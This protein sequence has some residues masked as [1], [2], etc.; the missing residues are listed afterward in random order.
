M[1]YPFDR[2]QAKPAITTT[3]ANWTPSRQRMILLAL[4]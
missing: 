1:I 2:S 3:A 4:R